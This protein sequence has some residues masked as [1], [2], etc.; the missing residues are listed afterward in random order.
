MPACVLQVWRYGTSLDLT[1]TFDLNATHTLP[2][3]I[4]LVARMKRG[5]CN[6]ILVTLLY[7]ILCTRII[8][9][10]TACIGIYD[11][12]LGLYAAAAAVRYG[13]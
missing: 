2:S 12:L 4:I 8:H 6:V 1:L 9:M 5:E 7:N 10:T 3:V 11:S 13:L